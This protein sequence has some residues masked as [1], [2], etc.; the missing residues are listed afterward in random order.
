MPT[1]S[2]Q[3]YAAGACV[4]TVVDS[5]ID[6]TPCKMVGPTA[7][8][9][10]GVTP[11]SG[12]TNISNTCWKTQSSYSCNNN[13]SAQNPSCDILVKQ[14]CEFLSNRCDPTS[15]SNGVCQNY[16]GT[17]QCQTSPKTSH[18]EQNCTT[19][20]VCSQGNCWSTPTTPNTAFGASVTAMEIVREASV[21]GEN[22]RIFSGT[23]DFCRYGDFGL[24]D[25]CKPTDGAKSNKQV[26]NPGGGN[27]LGQFATSTAMSVGGSAA[28]YYAKPLAQ[29]GSAYV[30][31]FMSKAAS[32]AANGIASFFSAG[33][34]AIATAGE[35]AGAN[36][37]AGAAGSAGF[38]AMGFTYGAT[39]VEGMAA[40]STAISGAGT[41]GGP[42]YSMGGGFAFDPTSLAI[43][44]A[45]MVAMKVYA[46]MTS[47]TQEEMILNMQM[48]AN[49]CI[50]VGS[51]C[52]KS[53]PLLGCFEWQQG[54]CCYNS[55]LSKIIN[56]QG[57]GQLGKGFGS[58]QSP[59]CSGFAVAELAQL[60][61]ASMDFSQFVASIKPDIP[62]SSA[63]G[64]TVSSRISNNI[65][66]GKGTGSGTFN[67]I[68]PAK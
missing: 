22:G 38:G 45:I 25:C 9:L 41:M 2:A 18:Q 68:T 66:S 15:M 46:A 16:I 65:S 58:P 24:K 27:S 6:S 14:G 39:A 67:A 62:D 54:F 19:S 23:P 35:T 11:P 33:A 61:F 28:W 56:Q 60:D 44:V 49:L 50:S 30:Y 36:V 10:A 3:M 42:L 4:S 53:Y 31:D 48:G 7:V 12:G 20:T 64:Q 37:A 29:Q 47:C 40:S 57:R 52:S 13:V 59:D 51:Y 8:C 5:C 32:S 43:T 55:V 21:Y 17:Y 34:P 26:L 1:A 63:L